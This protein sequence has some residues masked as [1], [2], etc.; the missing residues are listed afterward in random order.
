MVLLPL[1]NRGS[2]LSFRPSRKWLISSKRFKMPLLSPRSRGC[3]LQKET[4]THTFQ[5][6]NKTITSV[7]HSHFFSN[8]KQAASFK[9]EILKRNKVFRNNQCIK[10]QC[11]QD[12]DNVKGP[13]MVTKEFLEARHVSPHID[14]LEW[15]NSKGFRRASWLST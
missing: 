13:T 8:V 4:Y 14:I 1:H 11:L 7:S 12:S 10:T 3:W 5:V 15:N 6:K 2:I 9:Q